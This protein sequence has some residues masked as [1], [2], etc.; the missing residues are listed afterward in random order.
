MIFFWTVF[1][2]L[3]LEGENA[4]K[5]VLLDG[6]F[7]HF[8]ESRRELLLPIGKFR[9]LVGEMF[10]L[11]WFVKMGTPFSPRLIFVL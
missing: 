3:L 8:A 6:I 10:Y 2:F 11:K 7:H 4:A 5:N 9:K 1:F